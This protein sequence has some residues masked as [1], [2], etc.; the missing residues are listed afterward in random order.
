MKPDHKPFQ[1]KV[2]SS[3]ISILVEFI[4]DRTSI[5]AIYN[6]LCPLC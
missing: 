3:Y 4:N 5:G 6:G 1:Q 2:L